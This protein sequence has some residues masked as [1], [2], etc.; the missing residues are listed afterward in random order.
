MKATSF[1]LDGEG[2][3][4]MAGGTRD[5]RTC[6]SVYDGKGMPSFDLLHSRD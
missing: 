3:A 2:C 1:L 6:A 4:P 5:A